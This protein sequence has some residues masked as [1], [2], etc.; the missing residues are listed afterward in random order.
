LFDCLLGARH[1]RSSNSFAV[2]YNGIDRS[3]PRQL[4]GSAAAHPGG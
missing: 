1:P 2:L 3:R 4:C